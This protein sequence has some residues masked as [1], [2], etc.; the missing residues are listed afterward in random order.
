[1]TL[2]W[3]FH[4]QNFIECGLYQLHL[5][6]GV[7]TRL[8]RT[9]QHETSGLVHGQLHKLHRINYA[10]LWKC[11]LTTV[12]ILEPYSTY[13]RSTTPSDSESHQN[14]G[15]H[16][17]RLTQ[18]SASENESQPRHVNIFLKARLHQRRHHCTVMSGPSS[19]SRHRLRHRQ[20]LTP[21][22][23]DFPR[24]AEAKVQ[25]KV[26]NQYLDSTESASPMGEYDE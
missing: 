16:R 13:S 10:V 21:E 6:L 4:D 11:I 14:H 24:G 17:C 9:S 15:H 26:A 18:S 19:A 25:P 2:R 3:G 20:Q 22:A 12:W 8:D 1:M 7:T 23:T 5:H